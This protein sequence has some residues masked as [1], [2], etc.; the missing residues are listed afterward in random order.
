MIAQ[1]FHGHAGVYRYGFYFYKVV[2][3]HTKCTVL[4]EYYEVKK[5]APK[6]VLFNI[7]AYGIFFY[8]LRTY[9]K[10]ENFKMLRWH[11]VQ[12][13]NVYIFKIMEAF[14]TK[15][16]AKLE[17]NSFILPNYMD[18]R[19]FGVLGMHLAMVR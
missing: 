1:K 3:Y 2:V 14:V 16:Q 17:S 19:K 13:W 6:V 15:Y 7:A 5:I 18:F 12:V 9:S 8:R 4:N 11:M 10:I